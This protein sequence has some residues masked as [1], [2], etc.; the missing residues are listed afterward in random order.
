MLILREK[1]INYYIF[2]RD[3]MGISFDDIEK[4]PFYLITLLNPTG[5]DAMWRLKK[6]MH[7]DN[8]KAARYTLFEEV[9]SQRS[10]EDIL[11]SPQKI[12]YYEPI[13]SRK[14]PNVDAEYQRIADELNK[15]IKFLRERSNASSLDDLMNSATATSKKITNQ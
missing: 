2:L 1:M 11:L 9:F 13:D 12:P 10:L 15:D 8:L 5:L 14:N 7:P 3:D 6:V 4:T